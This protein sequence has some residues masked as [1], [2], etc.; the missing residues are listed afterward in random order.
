MRQAYSGVEVEALAAAMALSF[1]LDIGISRAVL[2]G[3]SWVV[4]K[5]LMD[6]DSA[7]ASYGLLV[8]DVKVLSKNFTQLLYPH[9]KGGGN[10]VA[11]SRS[12]SVDRGHPTTISF[13]SS[14]RF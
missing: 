2:E 1:A 9:T 10:S 11:H 4:I 8:D 3:D 5:A 13:C 14:S 12:L 6:D 7:L